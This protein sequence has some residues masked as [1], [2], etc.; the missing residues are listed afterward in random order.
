MNRGIQAIS[1]PTIPPA[2]LASTATAHHPPGPR[3]SH[4]MGAS[5]SK[6][7]RAAASAATRRQ[8]PIQPSPSTTTSHA[9]EPTAPKRKAG[10]VYH[11]KEQASRTKTEAIDLDARDPHFAASLRSIGPV[12]PNPTLSHSSTFNRPPAST[13]S[14]SISSSSSS[15]SS[16]T[17]SFSA[18]PSPPNPAIQILSARSNLAKFAEQELESFGK[19]SHAGRQF[20]DVVTIKQ[21]LGMR[22]REGIGPD[23]IERHYRLKA[24]LVGRLGAKGVVGE[25]R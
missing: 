8:Y 16:S 21:I 25:V 22:D 11:S 13:T 9:Q 2:I 20:L 12:I 10:P 5:V 4:N 7:A 14:T 18:T 15:S 24:G 23:M 6:P 3:H 19:Q 17:S 1:P